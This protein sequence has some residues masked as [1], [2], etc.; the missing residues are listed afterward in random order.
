MLILCCPGAGDLDS[1]DTRLPDSSE[2]SMQYLSQC[3]LSVVVIVVVFPWFL[4]PLG[5]ITA[6]F[7]YTAR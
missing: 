6:L 7:I 1:I 4:V 2:N 5:P 3:V